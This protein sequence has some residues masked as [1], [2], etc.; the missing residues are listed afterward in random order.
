MLVLI[1][2]NRQE[3]NLDYPRSFVDILRHAETVVYENF[4]PVA[5]LTNGLGALHF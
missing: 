5:F 1:N 3:S 4:G 2:L